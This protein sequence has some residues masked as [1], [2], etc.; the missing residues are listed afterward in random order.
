MLYYTV[1]PEVIPVYYYWIYWWCPLAWAY[2]GVIVNQF[3]SESY[4]SPAEGRPSATQGETILE[5][6]G[7]TL[8]GEAFTQ[9]WIAYSFVYL[10][11]YIVLMILMAGLCLAFVRFEV[12]KSGGGS[13]NECQEEIAPLDNE[14]ETLFDLPFIPIDLTFIDV[15]F[16]VKKSTESNTIKLLNKVNGHLQPGRMCA[17]MGSSGAGKTTLME[18][19]AL[20]K[21]S[22]K[23][24]GEVRLNGHLQE[25]ASF[26]RCSGYVDQFDVQT[27]ELTVRE[28]ILFSARLRLDSSDPQMKSDENKVKFVDQIIKTMELGSQHNMLVGDDESGGLSFEQRKRLSIAVELAASP[29]VIFLDEPV[30]FSCTI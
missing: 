14:E 28:T 24:D 8:D 10:C 3:L 12:G 13:A 30:S 27:P 11:P 9:E 22:G 1:A 18:V 29:S 6:A 15:C 2:R 7:F 26:R 16:E 21:Q 23:I 25:S 5:N 17:L 19:I 20:R 4:S